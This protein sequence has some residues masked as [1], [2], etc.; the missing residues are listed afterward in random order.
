MEPPIAQSVTS[1]SPNHPKRKLH[2]L[3]FLLLIATLIS[4]GATAYLL[5]SLSQKTLLSSSMPS[6]EANP[7]AQNSDTNPFSNIASSETQT[8]ANPFTKTNSDN[9][10]DQF[11]TGNNSD[12]GS[13]GQY[14]NPF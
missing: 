14:Q 9:P 13:S 5:I 10:F 7:F 2:T 4:A 11:D 12:A 6:A 8:V 3:F 1:S